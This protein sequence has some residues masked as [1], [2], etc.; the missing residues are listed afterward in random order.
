METPST[1]SIY[2]FTTNEWELFHAIK[3]DHK[4]GKRGRRERTVREERDDRPKEK[5]LYEEHTGFSLA[6][7][8][9]LKR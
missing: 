5:R 3:P 9:Q 6:E 1:L 2:E 4:V 7:L 8:K